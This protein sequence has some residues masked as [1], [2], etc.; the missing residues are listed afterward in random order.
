MLELVFGHASEFDILHFHCDYVHFPLVRRYG[1]ATVTTMHGY[2][3]SHDLLGLLAEYRDVP[4]VSISEAQ[5]M[6]IAEANWCGTVHH[7]LPSALHTFRAHSGSYL[8]FLGRISPDKG[9]EDAIEVA[10]ITSIPLR[11][12]A[13]IYDEDRSYF[14]NRIQP[15]LQ[16]YASSIEFVGELGGAE[17]DNFLGHARALLFPVRWPEPFG[18]VMIEAMAC[19]TPVIAWRNGAVPEVV[20]DGVT[21]FIVDSVEEALGCIARLDNIR[22]ERCRFAFES[23]F[24]AKR[25]TEDYLRIYRRIIADPR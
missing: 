2:L 4:L 7:G 12:A 21:G 11:I 22:R 19:G 23:R 15:L 25:M 17:K 24:S 5:R 18:L 13:K 10:R 20:E 16:Q 14:E 3:H 9:I 1:C 6:P 8:A